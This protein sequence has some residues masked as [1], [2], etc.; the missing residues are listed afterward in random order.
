MIDIVYRFIL[1][2]SHV[3]GT[4]QLVSGSVSIRHTCGVHTYT[5]I[6]AENMHTHKIKISASPK[7]VTF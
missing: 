2:T 6:H 7:R 3:S 5:Y 4:I 1:R